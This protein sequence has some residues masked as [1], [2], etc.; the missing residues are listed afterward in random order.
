[1]TLKLIGRVA[2][3][4]A[5]TLSLAACVDMTEDLTVTSET[6]A[7]AT[8]TMTMGADIY[9]M[10]KAANTSDAKSDDKFCAK[11]GETLTENP[12]GTATCVSS[13]E[14]D[15]SALTFN[16]GG[17]KPTF[18]SAGPGLVRVSLVTKDL[19]GDLGSSETQDAETKAM[20]KQMFDGHFLTLR[21][22]G[23]EVTDTNM[24]LSDDHK[25]A[26]LKVPFTEMLDG[27]A[28]LPDELYAVV[29]AN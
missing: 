5:L 9:A 22:G 8:M 25:T 17:S 27:T 28:K 7:K 23:A 11:P 20:M 15:F 21:F 12:D 14:G 26:E 6:T 16:E 13:T 18:T 24:T 19:M 29:K 10:L 1:M 4:L 3:V 2:G